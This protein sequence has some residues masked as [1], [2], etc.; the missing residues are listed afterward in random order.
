MK[1]KL[2]N[3]ISSFLMNSSSS[4]LLFDGSNADSMSAS[5][6]ALDIAKN[7]IGIFGEI[8]YAVTKW[9]MYVVDIIFFYIRQLCGL[10]MDMSSL[11]AAFSEESDIVFNLLLT[12]SAQILDIV[13]ALIGIAIVLIIVFSIIAIIKNQF[14][15]LKNDAPADINGVFRTALKSFFL[16]IIVPFIAILGIV[17]SNVLLKSL[18]NATNVFGANSLSTSVFAASSTSANRYREYAIDG[19]RIPIYYDFSK[20]Q[21][22]LDYYDKNPGNEN[23]DSYLISASNK[24]YTTYQMFASDSFVEFNTLRVASQN[25]EYYETF[26]LNPNASESMKPYARI[27]AY[28]PEYFVMADVIDYAV[29]SNN[30]LYIKSIEQVMDSIHILSDPALFSS[31]VNAFNIELLQGETVVYST[32]SVDRTAY[33]NEDWNI[34][35]FYSDYIGVNEEGEPVERQ[36]IE[37]THV[38]GATDEIDGAVFI[39]TSGKDGVN[40]ISNLNQEYYYPLCRGDSDYG[41]TVFESEYIRKGQI[42]AA[43]GIFNEAGHPTAIKLSADSAEVI[44]Y[45]D[46]LVELSLGDT[47][48]ILGVSVAESNESGGIGRVFSAIAKFFKAL[49]NPASLVPNLSLDTAAVSQSYTKQTTIANKLHDG[50][51]LHLSYMFSDSLTNAIMDKTY[52]LKIYNI[53]VPNNMNYFLLVVGTFLLLKTCFIA[54]FALIKRA[55]DLF[56]IILFYPTVCGLYPLD[57]GKSLG[58]WFRTYSSK[59]FLTYGLI[60]GINFV[61]MLF[62]VI[63]SIEF[64]TPSEVST[65]KIIRRIGVLFFYVLTPNQIAAMMNLFTAVFF[66]LVAFTMLDT[67]P[68]M[69]GSITGGESHKTENTF[70]DIMKFLSSAAAVVGKVNAVTSLLTKAGREKVKQEFKDKASQFVPMGELVGAAKDRI[71]LEKKKHAQKD[72]YRDLQ[73]TLDS[74]SSKKEDVEKAMNNFLKAQKG[75]TN[76][77]EK[78]REDRKAEDA[79]KKDENKSGVSSRAK[80][81]GGMTADVKTDRELDKDI[82]NAQKHLKYLAKKEKSGG[83]SDEEQKAKDSYSQILENAQSEKSQR[84]DDKQGL[85]DADKEIKA[86]EEKKNSG[87]ELSDEE[88]QKLGELTAKRTEIENRETNRTSGRAK[89]KEEIKEQKEK[90]KEDKKEAEQR[91]K[92]AKLFR[93]TG[94][95]R[96]QKKRLKELDK[97]AANIEEQFNAAGGSIGDKKL[98]QMSAEEIQAAVSDPNSKLTTEQM[99]LLKQY[100]GKKNYAQGLVGIN[101][102]EHSA[103]QEAKTKK[104]TSKDNKLLRSR[105]ALGRGIRGRRAAKQ[106]AKAESK[107]SSVDAQLASFGPVN[108]S[109]LGKYKKLMQQ[110][111]S[112]EAQKKT[113]SSFTSNNTKEK[114]TEMRSDAKAAKKKRMQTKYARRN[115]IEYLSAHGGD[116]SERSIQKHM[117][118]QKQGK[119]KDW[120]KKDQEAKEKEEEEKQKKEAK[121]NKGKKNTEEE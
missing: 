90:E 50:G 24:I 40:K 75:Y 95:G 94:N 44:F 56:L 83:L 1:F 68:E 55:Y 49:F 101:E 67:A 25:D 6:N 98:S 78:P 27:R 23:M 36:Q 11:N 21:E 120:R 43:K 105:N 91:Q 100:Q 119:Y 93:H 14:N 31:F 88:K 58:E 72:A 62:P 2:F 103:A 108:A 22:I 15:S 39:M 107:L 53:F 92:D 7:V 34:I 28:Q 16:I 59:I 96:Q 118:E 113:S 102:A 18:Y 104:Q 37:Y 114:R 89:Q 5:F 61:I 66:Q 99:D 110:K 60:L 86:L 69:I 42:V 85:K 4:F 74:N 20:Q 65:T 13:K 64:F 35:R 47:G 63:Q 52:G 70:G 38:R 97:E 79:R 10:E 12:N 80:D 106:G 51:K 26:D 19:K 17:A 117:A 109:N 115:A 71:N 77:L 41:I 112:L 87:F 3:L 57:E 54:I 33:G 48:G 29:K 81:E 8:I 111:A 82:K 30:I 84:K 32:G 9:G 121:K 76:A 73:E 116:L 46:Q 45:R